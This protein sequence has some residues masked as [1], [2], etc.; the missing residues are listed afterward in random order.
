MKS[1]SKSSLVLR[2][3][4]W[5]LTESLYTA[6]DQKW[7]WKPIL[8]SQT[9]FS[10]IYRGGVVVKAWE[11]GYS[12]PECGIIFLFVVSL[13]SCFLAYSKYYQISGG[14]CLVGPNVFCTPQTHGL[15]YS[16]LKYFTTGMV[17]YLLTQHIQRLIKQD[18]HAIAICICWWYHDNHA[19]RE[20]SMLASSSV[21]GRGEI[22][23]LPWK[24]RTL[25]IHRVKDVPCFQ[26]HY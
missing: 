19:A 7:E 5:S 10:V 8:T 2:L 15:T 18:A 22:S 6:S 20:N 24:P 13:F 26:I 1:Y 21:R 16:H 11:R 14:E 12:E 25:Y 17:C 9:H 4:L 23:I 3:L